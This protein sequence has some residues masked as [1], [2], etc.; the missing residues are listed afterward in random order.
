M[1]CSIED[2]KFGYN[3]VNDRLRKLNPKVDEVTIQNAINE[4]WLGLENNMMTPAEK[5]VYRAVVEKTDGVARINL[6]GLG[7]LNEPMV[8]IKDIGKEYVVHLLS[9]KNYTFKKGSIRS[10]ETAKKQAVVMPSMEFAGQI[11]KDPVLEP[12]ETIVVG[13]KAY[14]NRA[15]YERD[16]KVNTL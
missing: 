1:G 10:N 14:M 9:G 16:E 7:Q 11:E 15:A 12:L 8:M 13:G 5:A 2:Q 3:Q 6:G 4:Y